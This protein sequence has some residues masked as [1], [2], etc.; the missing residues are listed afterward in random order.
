[1]TWVDE[2]VFFLPKGI[3]NAYEESLELRYIVNGAFAPLLEISL[4]SCLNDECECLSCPA[5]ECRRMELQEVDQL[6]TAL[7]KA[8]QRFPE[9]KKSA[10][11]WFG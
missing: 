10:K 4:G 8:R 3:H 11:H 2:R 7:I 6:I 5:G 9:G 1:M